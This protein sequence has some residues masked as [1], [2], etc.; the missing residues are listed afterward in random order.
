M[1]IDSDKKALLPN[2][3]IEKWDSWLGANFDPGHYDSYKDR[4]NKPPIWKTDIFLPENLEEEYSNIIRMG[5]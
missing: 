5:L 1:Y 3:F 2:Y 4:S